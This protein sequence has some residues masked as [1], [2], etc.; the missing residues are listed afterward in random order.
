MIGW[1]H[2]KRGSIYKVLTHDAKIQNKEME[3]LYP[4]KQWT[5]YENLSDGSVYVRMTSE[6]LDGRFEKVNVD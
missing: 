4:D 3:Y 2:K 1:R 6:F 5:V